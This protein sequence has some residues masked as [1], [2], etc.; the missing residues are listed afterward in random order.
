MLLSHLYVSVD[1]SEVQS[2]RIL[3][4]KY[5]CRFILENFKPKV[6]KNQAKDVDSKLPD[7]SSSL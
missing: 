2:D 1:I 7:R 6:T 4:P 3:I 5:D